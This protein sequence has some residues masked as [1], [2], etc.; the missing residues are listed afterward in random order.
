MLI[1]DAWDDVNT[2]RLKDHTRGWRFDPI[3]RRWYPTKTHL[4]Q[5]RAA[6]DRVRAGTASDRDQL[7]LNVAGDGFGR[8]IGTRGMADLTVNGPYG[9]EYNSGRFGD[10]ASLPVTAVCPQCGAPNRIAVDSA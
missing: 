8:R 4:A 1:I 6:R 10:T 9:D 2:P 3:N 7:I 5:R